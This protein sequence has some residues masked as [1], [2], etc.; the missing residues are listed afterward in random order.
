MCKQDRFINNSAM[1]TDYLIWLDYKRNKFT[2]KV[3]MEIK[4][5]DFFCS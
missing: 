1:I 4:I 5:R 3:H 2:Y